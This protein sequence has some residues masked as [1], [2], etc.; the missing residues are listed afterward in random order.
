VL[1]GAKA[2]AMKAALGANATTQPALA[3]LAARVQAFAAAVIAGF[4]SSAL[5]AIMIAMGRSD[6]PHWL[7]SLTP[8]VPLAILQ[9]VA[10]CTPRRSACWW[11][12]APAAFRSP[13]F[14]SVARHAAQADARGRVLRQP[15]IAR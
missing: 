7:A 5:L 11:P 1:W 14:C 10:P 6:Y 13:F 3:A 15:L 8:V 9:L 12:A 2:L 4:P